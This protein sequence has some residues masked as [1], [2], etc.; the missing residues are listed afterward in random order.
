MDLAQR[1][2]LRVEGKDRLDF[3]NRLLSNQIVDKQSKMAIAAGA[4]VY[5]FMLNN[6]GRI[7]SDMTVL[8]RGEFAWVQSDATLPR[9]KAPWKS[10]Y[11]LKR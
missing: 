2:L 5:S 11:F 10:S 7:I 6:K 4:G 8:E 1:G 3:L 9:S